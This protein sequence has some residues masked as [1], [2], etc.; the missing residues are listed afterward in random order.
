M[1]ETAKK[2]AEELVSKFMPHVY[3]YMG[4]GMLTN[5][6]NENVAKKE[7]KQCAII[8][9]Y[10]CIDAAQYRS[11]LEIPYKEIETVEFWKDVKTEIEAL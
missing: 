8:T 9:V 2:K 11:K 1:N 5:D 6:Y 10:E 7:A 3:C 4:S